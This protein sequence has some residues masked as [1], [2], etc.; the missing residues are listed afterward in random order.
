MIFQGDA[1]IAM[2]ANEVQLKDQMKDY[3][4]RGD[5]LE[6]MSLFEFVVETYERQKPNDSTATNAN[7]EDVDN[8][9]SNRPAGR[10]LR[11]VRVPYRDGA[12]KPK[13]CRVVRAEG[14]DTVP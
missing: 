9:N 10:R 5:A 4:F 3:Q 6:D 8:N 12:G 7:E 13:M 11:S 14:H 2:V 1:T